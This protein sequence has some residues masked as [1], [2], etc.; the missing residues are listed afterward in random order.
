MMDKLL[1][2]RAIFLL[3]RHIARA[4]KDLRGDGCLSVN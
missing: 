4:S 2:C 3:E 1:N